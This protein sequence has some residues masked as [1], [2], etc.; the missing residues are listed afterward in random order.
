[1]R[2]LKSTLL[3][4]L[5]A[6]FLVLAACGPKTEAV[7][8]LSWPF[9][10]K[11][12]A[13]KVNGKDFSAYFAAS[14]MH[15]RRALNGLAIK[16]DQA[17][18][19]LY[20]AQEDEIEIKLSTLSD[21]V[22]LV[23]I[24]A[25]SKVLKVESVPAFSQATFPRSFAAKGARFVLQFR[26]GV[27]KDLSLSTG[28]DVKTEPNLIDKADKAE[29]EFAQLF[30][31]RN[32]RPEDK[33]S[34]APSVQLKVLEKAEDVAR[35]MKD[36]DEL[37]DG[38]G[39][40]VPY[41]GGY[42]EFWLKEVKGKVCACFIERVGTGYQRSTV[43]S[44]IYEGIEDTGGSDLDRPVYYSPTEAAYLAV[45]KGSDFFTKNKI[46]KRSPVTIAGV[47]VY[48]S[49]EPD[50]SKL[51]LK[52]GDKLLHAKLANTDDSRNA[53]LASAAG[54]EAD[55]AI[56][57]AWDDPSQVAI[58]APAGVNL[59]FVDA[60]GGKYSVGRK[61]FGQGGKVEGAAKSRFVLLVPA[62][63]EA[64][65]ELKFP[66]ALRDLRPSLPTVVFYTAKPADVVT[67]RWPGTDNN[68]KGRARVELAITPAE[69]RR[70][71]MY[72]ESLRENHGMIFIYTQELEDLSYWMKNCRMNLSIAFVD[73]KGVIVKIHNVMK[74]PAP[75]TPDGQLDHYEAGAPAKYAIEMKENWFSE[76]GIKE[77]DRVFI[78]PA[79][80]NRK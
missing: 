58:D 61:V 14:E 36:R 78:P 42:H 55:K 79:L 16:P 19:Y 29:G 26:Q 46:E 25:S 32:Q 68:A 54:L 2:V 50:Y 7:E 75:G 33:P 23:F 40:I 73:A 63:F 35:F 10:E 21:P 18:A 77:G 57:L 22:E 59:W 3:L 48:Q 1:M 72:R 28:S 30:F 52:F 65:G 24:D 17:I 51:E 6:P 74:A 41:S 69:Q 44:A 9:I 13:L 43:I 20:P 34:D 62:G 76:K 39:V 45:W 4:A 53:A 67:D 8:P 70:G 11:T 60:D 38:Q 80:A 56:V 27:A 12:E 49:L 31:L 71:L 47:D 15:R 37:A 66:Y 5:A 64:S